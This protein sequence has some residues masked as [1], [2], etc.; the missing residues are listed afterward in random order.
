MD[1]KD[2]LS[3]RAGAKPKFPNNGLHLKKQLS[4]P[5]LFV[6]VSPGGGKVAVGSRLQ[7]KSVL[8]LPKESIFNLGRNVLSTH[9]LRIRGY[10]ERNRN[11][12]SAMNMAR[13]VP[14]PLF[15]QLYP[16]TIS[17]GNFSSLLV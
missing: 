15:D 4:H 12:I 6:I 10:L 11:E 9:E 2:E 7:H 8:G 1:I 14:T 17:S 5:T 3:T 13:H 16:P